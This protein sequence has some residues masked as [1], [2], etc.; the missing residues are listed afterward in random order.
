MASQI[1][2]GARVD[3]LHLL[4]S[5]GEIILYVGRRI[6]VVGEFLVVV[7]TVVV[8]AEAQGAMP[9]HTGLLPLVPPIHF[10]P[11]LHEELHLHL[12]ELAHAEYELTRHDLVA[13][14]L[15]Y[16]CDAEREFHASRLL[17]VEVVDEDALRRFGAEVD[18]VGAFGG[19]SHLRREHEVE[20][21]HVGPVASA[22]N[23]AGDLA[24]EDDLAQLREVAGVHR[25]GE[26]GV[27]GVAFGRG[28][29]Y[30]RRG[31]AVLRLVE[32][33]AETLAGLLHLFLDLLVLLGDPILDQ[34]VGSVT[35]LRILVVDQGIV[36]GGD[37]ARGLPSLGVHEDGGVDAHDVFVQLHHRIPPVAFDVI[38]QFHAVLSVIV[39]GSQTVVYFARREYESVLLAVSDQLFEQLLLCHFR[40]D[41]IVSL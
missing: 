34:H 7:E 35:L 13:E 1:E 11:G 28:L 18:G 8:V 24:V 9:S 16:L 36:E 12:L 14:R 4:E 29:Q 3:T 19:R 38:L 30:A 40:I 15:A 31:G 10:G 25:L 37:V 2:V 21:A 6:C 41:F 5:E 32:R 17:H 33:L 27:H 39:N 23:G 22:R 20:L 26:A